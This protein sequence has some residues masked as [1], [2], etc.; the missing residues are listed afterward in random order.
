MAA[1][2]SPRDAFGSLTFS[3]D[4]QTKLQQIMV[5][6]QQKMEAV[7]TPE[8]KAELVRMRQQNAGSATQGPTKK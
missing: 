3:S 2:K 4:Q 1:G 6:S 7:L 8:Q 5:T